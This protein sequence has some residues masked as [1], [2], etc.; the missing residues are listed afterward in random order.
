MT[1]KELIALYRAQSGDDNAPYFCED[2]L[3]KIYA[4]EAQVEAC[5][6]GQLL[7]DT[8]R[9]QLEVNKELVKLPKHALRVT[10]AFVNRLP[11]GVISVQDMDDMHPGWQF[12][13]PNTQT[14]HLVSGVTTNSLHLWPCPSVLTELVMTVQALPKS[15]LCHEHDTPEIRPEA[16]AGLVDWMLYRAY[17][18]EDNDLYNDA[19]AGLALRRFETEFGTKASARNEELVRSG[20]A[21]MPGPIA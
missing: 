1:L 18:R 12:D 14:T 20:A 8:Q 7:V 3:L 4:N 13:A 15:P 19:K 16:H 11:V 2:D 10:R 17:S 5:R 6:R 21:M 9:V